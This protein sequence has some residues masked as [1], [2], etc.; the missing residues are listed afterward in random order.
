MEALDTSPSEMTSNIICS[1]FL[2]LVFALCSSQTYVKYMEQ[3]LQRHL[4]FR[5]T[6]Q[7]RLSAE[8][9][10]SLVGDILVQLIGHNDV[11][12]L[13]F[14]STALLQFHRVNAVGAHQY[15]DLHCPD[16]FYRYVPRIHNHPG[17]IP[18][19]GVQQTESPREKSQHAGTLGGELLTHSKAENWLLMDNCVFSLM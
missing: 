3:L 7:E 4:L 9:W 13:S 15:S 10:K 19:T 16:S 12:R 2:C 5:N 17:I 14:L 1:V 8:H 6:L 18:L 11:I